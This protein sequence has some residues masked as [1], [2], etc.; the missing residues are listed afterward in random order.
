MFYMFYVEEILVLFPSFKFS[1]FFVLDGSFILRSLLVL[2][3][4]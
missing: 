4:G 2:R 3:V 1:L